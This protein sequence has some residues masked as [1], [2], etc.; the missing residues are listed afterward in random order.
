MFHKGVAA[1]C[2]LVVGV[3]GASSL[4]C[5]DSGDDGADIANNEAA[6]K[7]VAS[8]K[9]SSNKGIMWGVN[10]HARG[11]IYSNP[12]ATMK[13]LSSLGLT[14]YRLGLSEDTPEKHAFLRSVLVAAKKYGI[15]VTPS[16]ISRIG[17]DPDNAKGIAYNFALHYAQDFPEIKVWEVGNEENNVVLNAFQST[18]YSSQFMNDPD[19][20]FVLGY[21]QGLSLGVK[22]GNP[23]AK[24]AIGDSG[25]C[26]YGFSQALWKSGLRWDITVFHPYSFYGHID[27]NSSSGGNCPAGNNGLDIRWKSFGRPIWLTEFNF[28][29][30]TDHGDKVREGAGLTSMM[31]YFTS[32]ANTYHIE[33]A[34]IYELADETWQPTDSEK[35]FGIFSWTGGETSTS[36]TVRSWL[37]GQPRLLYTP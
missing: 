1:V 19:Y 21:M 4:G 2:A 16:L 12:D 20:P 30:A 27:D 26:N 8:T 22:A 13:L 14:H 5:S 33:E 31:A 11:P 34:D 28:T 35:Y 9:I 3:L 6:L 29:L 7:A 10:G 37:S 36:T 18:G 24:I 23:S 32:I 25:G 17:K 15:M